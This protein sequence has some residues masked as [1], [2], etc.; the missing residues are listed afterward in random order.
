MRHDRRYFTTAFRTTALVLLF[1]RLMP[2]SPVVAAETRAGIARQ[3]ITPTYPIRLSGYGGRRDETSEVVHPLWAKAL[4]F[5][6]GA[7]PPAVLITVDNLGVPAT[8]VDEVAARLAQSSGLARERLAV[9]STHT[10][11][12]PCLTNVAPTLFSEPIPAPHQAHI[13]RYTRELTDSLAKVARAALADLRPA[14]LHWGQGSVDFAKNR[15]TPGGPV[16]HDLPLLRVTAPDGEL[17]AVLVNYA[18]HCTALD[19]NKLSGDWA[20]YAQIHLERAHPGAVAMVA[21]G[22]GADANPEPRTGH[23]FAEQQGRAIAQEVERVLKTE[24][25][26]VEADLSA[27][28]Q[29]IALPFDTLPT[30]A[31][32]EERARQPGAVGYHAQVQLARLTAGQSLPTELPYAIQTW[33]FG[34]ALTMVFLPGEVMV[35]YSLRLKREL[36]RS[37]LWVNAYSNDV[38][39]YIPSRRIL[40]EGGYEGSDAMVYYDRPTRLAQ[41]VEELIVGT[42]RGLVPPSIVARD[43]AK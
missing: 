8:M 20:G 35:D 1:A 2:L 36:D 7:S 34:D 5:Q 6:H 21:I 41:A 24:L 13:D 14:H 42:V 39:C 25:R 11:T 4:A 3:D 16:D 40:D 33:S 38:P 23:E 10:H 30:K 19:D 17:R 43:A 12:A 27:Q 28:R 18:C 37:R 32:W 9:C 15:R 22:C 29:V 31:E 26:P